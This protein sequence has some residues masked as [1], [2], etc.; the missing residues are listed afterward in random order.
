MREHR[1][2]AFFG[3]RIDY[4]ACGWSV[5]MRSG[6]RALRGSCVRLLCRRRKAQT[7]GGNGA[8]YVQQPPDPETH[9]LGSSLHCYLT[10]IYHNKLTIVNYDPVSLGLANPAGRVADAANHRAYAALVKGMLQ[11]EICALGDYRGWLA[12]LSSFSKR[13]SER[14]ESKFVLD[15]IAAESRYPKSTDFCSSSRAFSLSPRPA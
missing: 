14:T 5:R 3:R 10:R 15:L 2:C 1:F 8:E 9:E 6:S 7:N 11:A 4:A 12:W 13:G